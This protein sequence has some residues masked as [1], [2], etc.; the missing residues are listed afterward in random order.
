[1]ADDV[2]TRYGWGQ[3]NA[4]FITKAKPVARGAVLDQAFTAAA[5]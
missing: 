3:C 4:P 5:V 2:H 1:M